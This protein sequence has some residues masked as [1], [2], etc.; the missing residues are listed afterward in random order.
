MK[1]PD[2]GRQ[3][4]RAREAAQLNGGAYLRHPRARDHRRRAAEPEIVRPAVIMPEHSKEA[5]RG[6]RAPGATASCVSRAEPARPKESSTSQASSSILPTRRKP[7]PV[8]LTTARERRYFEHIAASFAARSAKEALERFTVITGQ[9]R[10]KSRAISRA[11]KTPCACTA[12]Q[13]NDSY[14]FNWLLS[15]APEF[16]RPFE[17]THECDAGTSIEPRDQPM[18]RLAADPAPRLLRHRDRATSRNTASA[19]SN[20]WGPMNS[21]AILASWRFWTTVIGLRCP[22]SA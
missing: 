1:G 19:R 4:D 14:N 9:S 15:V 7:L 21:P 13:H 18:H 2:E 22:R 10:R 20:A 5:P 8:V 17:V 16:Q 12:K 11:D 3:N 6:L